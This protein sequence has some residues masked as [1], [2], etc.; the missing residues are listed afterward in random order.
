ML[1]TKSVC[2]NTLE[3]T[4]VFIIRNCIVHPHNEMLH[5]CKKKNEKGHRVL[6]GKIPGYTCQ[7]KI[8]KMYRY[9]SFLFKKEGEI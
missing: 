6:Y 1:H 9:N 3:I 8:K 2:Y 4:L 7:M 5:S